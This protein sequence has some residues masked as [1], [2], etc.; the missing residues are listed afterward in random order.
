VVATVFDTAPV[1]VR[2]EQLT[3]FV[4]QPACFLHIGRVEAFGEPAQHR[5]ELI[6]CSIASALFAQ[7]TG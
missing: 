1:H 6:P 4:Q 2:D 7:E 3:E 5:R